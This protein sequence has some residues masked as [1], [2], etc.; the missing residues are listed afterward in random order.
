MSDRTAWQAEADR[1]WPDAWDM[2][3][4]AAGDGPWATVAWCSFLTVI[5]HES[6][7]AGE[8][9]LRQI[10]WGR[11]GHACWGDHELVNLAEPERIE[12]DAEYL[13][14][15]QRAEHLRACGSCWEF[16]ESR[17]AAPAAMKRAA[18]RRMRAAA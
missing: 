11:C 8:R 2:V 1:R 10:S 14:G 3:E 5:L 9:A 13:R 7:E 12:P 18:S 6:R 4:P 16:V 17:R 15:P